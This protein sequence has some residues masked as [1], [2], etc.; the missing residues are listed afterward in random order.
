MHQET[1]TYWTIRETRNDGRQAW[2]DWRNTRI[3]MCRRQEEEAIGKRKEREA[4]CRMEK[5]C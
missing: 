5:E 3:H 4:R 1:R 2:N